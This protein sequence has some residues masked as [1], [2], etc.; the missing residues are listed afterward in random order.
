MASDESSWGRGVAPRAAI[1]TYRLLKRLGLRLLSVAERRRGLDTD[2]VIELERFELDHVDRGCYVASGWLQ[3]RRTLGAFGLGSDDVLVDFG[4][5]KGRVVYIAARHY[6]L[7]RVVG[8]EISPELSAVARRNV[9]R[10]R[11]VLRCPD[12]ELV[13]ADVLHYPIPDDLTVAYFFNPFTGRHLPPGPS[14]DHR[15]DRAAATSRPARHANP[16]MHD[17]VVATGAFSECD[18]IWPGRPVPPFWRHVTVYESSA[19]PW[20]SAAH[21]L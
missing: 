2:E 18:P 16:T 1:A 11:H 12:V 6:P 17:A 20:P 4:S 5:G 10:H 13:T 3:T 19:G 8:V 15:V 21:D 14:A 9:E 7:R